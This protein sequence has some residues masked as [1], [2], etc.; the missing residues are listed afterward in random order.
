MREK[1]K[2]RRKFRLGVDRKQS[3]A[4]EHQ[5]NLENNPLFDLV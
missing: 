2:R 5:R 3:S 1:P 4:R